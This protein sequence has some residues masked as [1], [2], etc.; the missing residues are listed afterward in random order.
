[1]IGTTVSHFRVLE[2]LGEGGMGVVYKAQDLALERPVALKFLG[3]AF[4]GSDRQRERLLREA[5]A[6]AALDHP[7]IC[8]VYEIGE[9]DGQL[10]IA[11]AFA[12]GVTLKDRVAAGPLPPAEAVHIALQIAKALEAAHA[13]GIVHRDVKSA[14]VLVTPRGHARITDFGLALMRAP[15]AADSPTAIQGTPAYM[16]PE[17]ITGQPL[18]H[19]TDIWSWGVVFYEMLT[20]RLPFQGEHVMAMANAILR[21]EPPPPS[22]LQAAVPAS[23]DRVLQRA[24]AKQ[25][26]DRF[27]SA[28]ELVAVLEVPPEQLTLSTP[29]RLA[30]AP[31]AQPR[32][33]VLPFK[34][35]S[36]ARDQDYFCEGLAEE[37]IGDLTRLRGLQ[38]VSRTSSFSFKDRMEDVR[39]IG[40]MLGA[41]T[42]LEGSVRKDGDR[43]RV[44]AQLIDAVDGLH[45]WSERYD[46]ELRDVFAIQEEI[47]TKIVQALRVE[48]SEKERRGLARGSTPVA[49][50]Y[51]FFLRGLQFFYRTRRRD[52]EYAIAMFRRAAETDPCFARA[53]AGLAY[54]H[55][56]L[57]FYHGGDPAHL[58]QALQA[59]DEALRLDPDLADAHAAHG[60]ALSLGKRLEDAETEFEVA[61]ALDE[62]L[63]EAHFFYARMRIAQ[64]RFEQ[65]AHLFR[66]AADLDPDDYQS[67]LL[68]AFALKNVKGPAECEAAWHVALGRARRHVSLNPDDARGLYALAQ[69]LVEL[70]H[71]DEGLATARAMMVLAP[72]DPYILYGMVCILA[73]LGEIDEAVTY[74]E[75]A[76]RHGFVQRQWIENDSDLDPIRGH[77]TYQALVNAL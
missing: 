48:I 15:G 26:A 47:A 31:R 49:D 8:P 76:V 23:W 2:K 1:M 64:G 34:D 42:L 73:R 20:G 3:A 17:Q 16:S 21:T 44:T 74:F 72:D 55:C 24:L 59:S 29:A 22:S 57:F 18:D 4:L 41:D 58:E 30:A 38:V 71:R 27:A 66:R 5:R 68:C 77:P 61:I 32:M 7:N 63:F 45:L 9:H 50:A 11:M 33:A 65:A 43:L 10:F 13:R 67:A 19:H 6:A 75:Q 36:P 54:C 62:Y 12:E 51:D 37:I 60:Y 56:Y 14:N 40:R 52:L 69:A 35:M 39:A 25:P 46:R 28:S 53:H 70:G